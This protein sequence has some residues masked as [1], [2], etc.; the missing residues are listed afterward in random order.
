MLTITSDSGI[1]DENK[2]GHLYCV[3]AESARIGEAFTRCHAKVYTEGQGPLFRLDVWADTS[4]ARGC[5][6][7]TQR[8]FFT[9]DQAEA[10]ALARQSAE[11][12]YLASSRV[13]VALPT[14]NLS[15]LEAKINRF[16]RRA[17]KLGRVAP[18]FVNLGSVVR[19]MSNEAGRHYY[20]NFSVVEIVGQVPVINGWTFIGS[21]DVLSGD[22]DVRVALTRPRPGFEIPADL[23]ARGEKL[24]CD[25]CNKTRGRIGVFALRNESGE[26][27]LVGRSCLAQFIGSDSVE[28]AVSYLQFIDEISSEGDEDEDDMPRESRRDVMVSLQD[29][30]AMTCFSIQHNGWVSR[31]EASDDFSKQA[32]ASQV[33]WLL[34]I[35]PF[36]KPSDAKDREYL[37]LAQESLEEDRFQSE[38]T[39]VTEWLK[40]I[41]ET[42]QNSDYIR[43]LVALAHL[44]YVSQRYVGV[45]AS[46]VNAYRRNKQEKIEREAKPVSNHVG[47]VGKRQ[48]FGEVTVTRVN[49]IDGT[50]GVTTI[51]NMVDSV[52]NVLVWFASGEYEA[53]QGDRFAVKATVKKHDSFRGVKQTVLTRAI[54]T[55]IPSEVKSS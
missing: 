37:K 24:H 9:R 47:V 7:S 52:G 16:A 22:G 45:A 6:N 17:A 31:K 54:L 51:L 14:Y 25:H 5:G 32:T 41:P 27:K 19:K 1:Q 43:N 21:I 26:Y 3:K 36:S 42:E 30:L 33:W 23:R 11:A 28:A 50:Y 10:V 15:R 39:A 4:D 20:E 46:A 49:P 18:H 12:G 48:E 53:S 35:G 13:F 38:A 40:G 34:A 8:S 29:T 2:V 44:G 55:K